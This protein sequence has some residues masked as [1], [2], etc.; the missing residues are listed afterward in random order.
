MSALTNDSFTLARFA[1]FYKAIQSAGS[2]ASS[3]MDA[4]ATPYLNE[5]VGHCKETSLLRRKILSRRSPRHFYYS[6]Y[7]TEQ[8]V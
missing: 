5:H 8:Q 2:A 4:T 3:G 6:G 1:G 7:A